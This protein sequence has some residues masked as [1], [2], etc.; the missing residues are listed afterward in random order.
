MFKGTV[1]FH[2]PIDTLQESVTGKLIR[3]RYAA[4]QV[5]PTTAQA[6][7]GHIQKPLWLVL[8]KRGV[9][10]LPARRNEVAAVMSVAIWKLPLFEA[11][12]VQFRCSFMAI[13]L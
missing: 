10:Q 9:L 5:L 3:D 1:V 6:P 4:L 8:F 13:L 2:L 12:Q 11:G 7:A